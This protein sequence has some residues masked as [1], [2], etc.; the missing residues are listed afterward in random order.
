M[1]DPS[2]TAIVILNWNG[3]KLLRQFIP[4]VIR[5]TSGA[6]VAIYVADNGS[7]DD[8][9]PFLRE[10]FPQVNPIEL[11]ANHGFAKGYN[12]ALQH[13]DATYYVLI[14]SDI[15][16]TPGWLEPCIHH[17]DK[18]PEMAA[19][20]PKILSYVDRNRFEYAGAAGGYIDHWGFPFCRGR[21]L[22]VTEEDTGQYDQP[23]SLFWATGA[24]LV[25]RAEAFRNSGGFDED[26][27]AHMEEI[28]LC[29]RL[30]NQGW[31]IGFE[32]GSTVYH[33]GGAT[34]SYHSPQKVY[35]NFRNNLWM[36]LKNLPVNQVLPVVF[37]RMVLDGVASMRFL[38]SGQVWA[39][40]A[41]FRAHRVFWRNLSRF[42]R[43]RK[44]LLPKVKENHH[45]EIFRGSMVFRFYFMNQKKFSE[46]GF[47][48][49]QQSGS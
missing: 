34:L 43:K 29:W 2:K 12:L 48:E 18:H 3:A 26:F 31:K 25:I 15:E 9:V 7:T 10:H 21:I 22:S 36:L 20:Q 4:Q 33:V 8:S 47:S 13:V 44:Q 49:N 5:Y 28:D 14:N 45:P 35:L 38:V 40:M 24:C 41:V 27:F 19:L 39:F 16:V 23:V 11:G 32:P 17:L 1:S 37:I 30:K 46:F 6:N 42:L